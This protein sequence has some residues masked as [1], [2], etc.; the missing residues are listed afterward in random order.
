MTVGYDDL[1]ESFLAVTVDMLDESENA[2]LELEQ[3]FDGELVN[4]V[5]RVFH[6]IK[7]DSGVF[8]LQKITDLAHSLENMLNLIRNKELEISMARIDVLLT[9]IDL[10]RQMIGDIGSIEDVS[11]D[12]ILEQLHKSIGTEEKPV[13]IKS[14]V[15]DVKSIVSATDKSEMQIEI[16]KEWKSEAKRQSKFLSVVFLDLLD[17]KKVASL[18][19]IRSSLQLLEYENILLMQGVLTSK[20]PGVDPESK[21]ILPYYLVLLTADDP[22]EF[23]SKSGLSAVLL[24]S[25]Y[26]PVSSNQQ[27]VTTN[28]VNDEEV[29][30]TDDK[31]SVGDVLLYDDGVVKEADDKIEKTVDSKPAGMIVAHKRKVKGSD[32]VNDV[33]NSSKKV[34]KMD[35]STDSYLKV[36]IDLLDD[37]INIAGETIIA[38]NSLVQASD[39]IE[40]QKLSVA[41]R[42]I[43]YFITKLQESIMRTRMQEIGTVFQRLP[44]LVR[45]VCKLTG[46]KVE[47]I[48]NGGDVELD[49]TLVDI[50]LDPLMHMVRNSIDH[51]IELP[52][53]RLRLGKEEIGRLEVK[54]YL[55]GGNVIVDIVDDGQGLDIE[56]IKRK[57]LR[58][59]LLNEEM[60]DSATDEEVFDL[61]FEPGFTTNEE[62]SKTS[63]RGV[64]M[65]VVRTNFK[66]VNGSVDVRS[67]FGEGTAITATIP[68]T[69]SIITTLMVNIDS[70]Q[71]AIPQQNIES[72]V[73]LE[74]DKL[75]EVEDHLMYNLRDSLFPLV[76]LDVLFNEGNKDNK[77]S[78]LDNKY[79]VFVYTERHKFG[80]IVDNIMNPEEI[81]VKPL[82]DH[83]SKILVFAGAAILGNGDAILIIDVPGVARHAK[84]QTNSIEQ[85]AKQALLTE[86]KSNEGLLITGTGNNRFAVPVSAMPRIERIPSEKIEVFMGLESIVFENEI[87]P[88]IRLEDIF[89]LEGR[90]EGENLNVMIFNVD[91]IRV[92]I[93]I[94]NIYDV[95]SDYP[96]LESGGF[97]GEGILGQFVLNDLKIVVLDIKNILGRVK[98]SKFG[99]FSLYVEEQK[100]VQLDNSLEFKEVQSV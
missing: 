40:N 34:F 92:G 74:L 83:F 25:I 62:V 6:T 91:T 84:L 89:G 69:L 18:V 24:K 77:K 50:I 80:L 51:G 42:K 31:E 44:R 30:L 53:E 95:I 47:L 88:L 17:Q 22:I 10:L 82:G 32:K 49:K 39:E 12:E 60:A 56:K 76:E 8:G 27:G 98:D 67:V 54:A 41:T 3:G 55:R 73:L 16:K 66:K 59:G 43:S 14:A 36:S 65:D 20:L 28:F 52:E 33:D 26:S 61:I 23:L 13:G 45:D 70:Q 63:G 9:G 81:V 87:V 75:V 38:R 72:I 99:N 86:R 79:I 68:Q 37:L 78:S 64:G 15:V 100:A 7:G 96:N 93:P 90:V 97:L 21:S 57:A 94:Q 2:L 58:I 46:K 29:A 11:I 85:K 1:L 19:N 48:T 35:V 4:S 5:F 71:Y